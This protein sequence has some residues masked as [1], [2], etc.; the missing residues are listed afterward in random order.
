MQVG[1]QGELSETVVLVSQSR[2]LSVVLTREASRQIHDDASRAR[3][4]P[5]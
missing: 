1:N 3:I 4:V 5:I 2:T